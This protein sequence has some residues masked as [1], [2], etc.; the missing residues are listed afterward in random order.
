MGLRGEK[1][2]KKCMKVG[3]FGNISTKD[4]EKK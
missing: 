2:M 3:S 1:G 4:R